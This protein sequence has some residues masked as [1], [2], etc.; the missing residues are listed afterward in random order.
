MKTEW[1]VASGEWRVAEGQAPPAWRAALATRRSPA[2]V[3]LELL[4]AVTI[5]AVGV[6]S[7]GQCVENCLRAEVARVEDQRA[8]LA[9]ENE[10]LKLQAAAAPLEKEKST[11]LKD[12][13]AGITIKQTSKELE[14]KNEKDQTL[15]GLREVRLDATWESGGEKQT[16]TVSFYVY[17]TR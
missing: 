15:S 2:F 10:M 13:F 3:L 4:L 12:M 1:R 16:K 6:I 17:R 9:L 8:R 11:E 7:L 5:F 14:F